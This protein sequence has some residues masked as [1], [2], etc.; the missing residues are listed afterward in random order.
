MGLVWYL[1][2]IMQNVYYMKRIL[3]IVGFGLACMMVCA[4]P[5]QPSPRPQRSAEDEAKFQ[6]EMLRHNLDLTQEQVDT[7]YAIHLRYAQLRRQPMS[8]QEAFDTME[9]LRAELKS[10]LTKEQFRDFIEHTRDMSPRHPGGPHP[11]GPQMEGTQP[12][13]EGEMPPPPLPATAE[14][15]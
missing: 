3:S 12:P 14:Q 4:Q 5:P 10:V 7:I 8:R 15:Q 1:L 11:G 9:D 13:M 2:V 6:T